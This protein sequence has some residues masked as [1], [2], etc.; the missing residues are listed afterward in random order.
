MNPDDASILAIAIAATADSPISGDLDLLTL[1]EV[2][3]IP[4]FTP[5]DFLTRYFPSPQQFLALTP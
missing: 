1:T 3:G 2:S 5:Q 4:I